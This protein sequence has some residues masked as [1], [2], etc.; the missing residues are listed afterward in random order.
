MPGKSVVL[1]LYDYAQYVKER[2]FYY[3]FDE[4]VAGQRAENF[5]QL[6][7]IIKQGPAPLDESR[8]RAL[9]EKFWGESQEKDSSRELMNFISNN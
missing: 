7:D 5:Q 2:D 6:M 1:Y 4:N 8:R 9:V 3:P